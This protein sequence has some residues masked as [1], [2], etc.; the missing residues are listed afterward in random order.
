[1]HVLSIQVALYLNTTSG[2]LLWLGEEMPYTSFYLYFPNT[3]EV[4]SQFKCI[5]LLNPFLMT[6]VKNCI[7]QGPLNTFKSCYYMFS[8]RLLTHNRG[9]WISP[10]L[11]I[12]V[13]LQPSK[14]FFHIRFFFTLA[15]QTLQI[16][17]PKPL[18]TFFFKPCK[19]RRKAQLSILFIIIL[20]FLCSIGKEGVKRNGCDC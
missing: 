3:L 9:Q 15:L 1:M 11:K 8:A 13:Q 4:G 2:A 16:V 20:F 7:N 6:V 14:V 10:I 19:W 18:L 12:H 5:G 17:C